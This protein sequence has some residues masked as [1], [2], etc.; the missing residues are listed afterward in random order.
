MTLE[1]VAGV[2]FAVW[3][4]NAQPGQRGRRLQRLGRPPPS[5]AQAHRV[6]RL[7]AVHPR[8]RRP[9]S[10]YKYEI[11]GPTGGLL[12][13][14][15]D[16][17]AFAAEQPPATASIVARARRL[18]LGAMQDWMASRAARQRARRADLDLR[19]PSRLLDAR[20]RGGQP[21]SHLRELADRLIP[22]VKDMG[23]THLELLPVIG[24]SRST[25]P[26]AISRSACSR[27]P[28]ATAAPSDF[29]RFVDRCHQAG[30]GVILDWVPGHF[31]TDPHGLGY[32]D[33]TAPLRAR[34]SAPGLPPRLEHADLQLRSARGR[35]LPARQRAVLAR[36]LS[37]RRAPGRCGR[38]DALSR[39]LAQAGRVDPEPVTAATRTSMRSPS[40][41]A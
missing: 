11:K 16:P 26:G 35:E 37:H 6:R 31:P 5:D 41:G 2:A 12:P 30:I 19:V 10:V 33:G 1:G 8:P 14:K 28:A 36:A 23:F 29:A 9:A 32:F 34:R 38:L 18:A 39:L 13:L 25:A 17:L 4:P 27:R 7:G 24:V 3:A 40:C 15:A 20:A 21:L 22:Y